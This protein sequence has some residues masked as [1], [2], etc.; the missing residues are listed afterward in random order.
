[1]KFHIPFTISPIDKLKKRSAPLTRFFSYRKKSTLGNLLAQTN[2]ELTREQY[3]AISLQ[4]AILTFIVFFILSSTIFVITKVERAIIFAI[5]IAFLAG[6]FIFFSRIVY[7]R[8]YVTR[9]QRDIERHLISALQDIHV[10]LQSGVPLFRIMVN[11][12][13][14]DY[15]ALSDEFKKAVRRINAGYPQIQVLEEL[16]EANPSVF[17]RRTLWQISNGMR[18][19]S[20]ISIVIR[21][22]IHAL[23]QEQLIQ[24]QNYGNKLNPM[25]M[26]YMLISVI[27]PA[28]SITFLTIISSL[29]QLSQSISTLLFIGLLVGVIIIQTMFLG[30]IKSIRPSLI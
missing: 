12:S 7:P 9:K 10:Q 8:V 11:I 29:V 5:A 3:L 6:L 28:L 21:E 15:G 17:F 20:D 16:G 18:A 23:S 26:F 24:I 19:G 14:S 22:S 1:M 30:V 2:I 4:G 27:L 13:S 25:I